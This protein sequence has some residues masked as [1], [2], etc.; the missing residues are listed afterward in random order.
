MGIV[1]G[2]IHLPIAASD[3][4]GGWHPT[5]FLLLKV[6]IHTR[7]RVDKPSFDVQAKVNS[8]GSVVELGSLTCNPETHAVLDDVEFTAGETSHHLIKPK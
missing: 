8:H 2:A 3:Q 6:R 7:F 4:K 1:L 5:K